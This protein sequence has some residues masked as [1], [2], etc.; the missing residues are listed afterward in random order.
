M[1]GGSLLVVMALCWLAQ[2][3]TCSAALSAGSVV[4]TSRAHSVRAPAVIGRACRPSAFGPHVGAFS[5]ARPLAA[6][7]R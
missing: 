7:P 2:T 1:G 4:L 5:L 6:T 3:V